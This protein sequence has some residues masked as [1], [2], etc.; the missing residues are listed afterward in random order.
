ME[1][2]SGDG[3]IDTMYLGG[4]ELGGLSSITKEE[5]DG[6]E[7]VAPRRRKYGSMGDLCPVSSCGHEYGQCSHKISE[8]FEEIKITADSGAVDHVAPPTLAR[9]TPIRETKASKQGV[10]YIAA[11]GS[12][13]KNLGEKC[14]KGKTE[15]GAPIAMTWQIAGVK[16]PLA[17]IGRICDA[18]NVAIFTCKGGFIMGGKGAKE[19]LEVTRRSSDHKMEVHRENGVYNFKIKVPAH[20]EHGGGMELRNRYAMLSEF[21]DEENS[22]GFHWPGSR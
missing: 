5:E 17:S 21:A 11:N 13:I 1:D 19:I 6:W 9:S 10:H 3:D 8:E 15:Q 2:L 22:K 18:G 20:K 16:K 12:E 14:I 4:L 7:R